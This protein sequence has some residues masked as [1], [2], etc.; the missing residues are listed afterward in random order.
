MTEPRDKDNWAPNVDRLSMGEPPEGAR[1]DT[2]A[3][4]RLTGPLQGFGQLWQKTYRV[5]ISGHTPEQVIATWKAEYGR[6]WPSYNRFYAP[7]AGIKPGEIGLIRGASG[8]VRMSTGVMVLYSDDR[9]FT[10]MTPEGHPFAGWITFSADDA[11]GTT[12]AQAQALIRANDPLY[13]MGMMAGG[14]RQEDR[15]WQHTL[16]ALAEHLGSPGEVQTER[17]KVDGHRQWARFGNIRHNS[18]VKT[19]LRR[20]PKTPKPTG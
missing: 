4:R 15:M 10:Y 11:D 19:M 2:V 16:A 1:A 13:E 14:S 18:I 8:P 9:S 12:H 5:P 3:G 6:F 7:I 20:A 17:V